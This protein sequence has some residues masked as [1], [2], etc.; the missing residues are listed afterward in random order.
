[1]TDSHHWSVS[2]L[3]VCHL[4]IFFFFK[5]T[6]IPVSLFLLPLSGDTVS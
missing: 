2:R 1:M 3:D 4:G 5:E 6:D